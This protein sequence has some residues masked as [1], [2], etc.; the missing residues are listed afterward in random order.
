MVSE[1][2]S[3]WQFRLGTATTVYGARVDRLLIS[4]NNRR[5]NDHWI[6]GGGFYATHTFD[7]FFPG[8]VRLWRNG[9]GYKG[10]VVPLGTP[11]APFD[12][13][14]ATTAPSWTSARATAWTKG[15]TGWRKARPG[16]PLAKAGQWVVE[17][18][19]LPRAPG[20]ALLRSGHPAAIMAAAAFAKKM[21][22]L[23]NEYLNVVFGWK[24]FVEDLHEVIKLHERLD[25][26]LADLYKRQREGVHRRREV[27]ESSST[28]N[29]ET[30]IVGNQ[31][32]CFLA[33][34]SGISIGGA[35]TGAKG[36]L[37]T[38]VTDYEHSWFVGK[39]R[40]YIPEMIE[41]R[42]SPRVKLAMYGALPTPSLLYEVFP[43]TWLAGWF[44][45]F[46]DVVSNVSANAVDNLVAD[47]SFIMTT[48]R[49]LTVVT[50]QAT[51]P[52]QNWSLPGDIGDSGDVTATRTY[53]WES[54]LRAY[55]SPYG[56]GVTYGSLSAYRMSILAAL[57]ISKSRF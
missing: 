18:R 13:T 26:H 34:D 38:S 51:W 5:K 31:L 16:N 10:P 6:S 17:L 40:Y 14:K 52:K 8:Q 46:G 36:R 27:S 45:N 48:T 49:R 21:S 20:R 32:A 15:S 30:P 55:A 23:G 19:D 12:I 39:F 47:Y 1:R 25:K 44:T 9:Q 50:A 56:F 54:R 41:G 37:I 11:R 43:W 28:T 3:S 53:G 57:G 35:L 42:M 29:T 24:P 22:A 7:M 33:G 2:V 4:Q